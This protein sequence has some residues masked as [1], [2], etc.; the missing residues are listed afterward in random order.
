MGQKLPVSVALPRRVAEYARR[1]AERL[2]VSLEEYIIDLLVGRLDPKDRV[3]EYI[4][5]AK[6]FLE[7][8]REELEKGNIRQA[9]EKIWGATALAIKAYAEWR[10]GK[11]LTSH[12]ELWKYKNKVA[13][14]LGNWVRRVFREANSLHTCFYK[15]WCTREDVEDVLGKVEKLVGEVEARVEQQNS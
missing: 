2:G 11:R 10:E 13:K 12:G 14:E 6:E 9:A 15:A 4:G 7:H 5:A 1:E 8:A 3:K